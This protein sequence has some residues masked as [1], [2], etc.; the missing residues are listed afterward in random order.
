MHHEHIPK[1]DKSKIQL[2]SNYKN[3]T[4]LFFG[5]AATVY[6]HVCVYI[7]IYIYIYIHIYI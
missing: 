7:Y 3:Q 1:R 2:K 4:S 6:A 5:N